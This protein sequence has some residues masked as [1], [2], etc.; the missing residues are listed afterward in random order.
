M[1]QQFEAPDLSNLLPPTGENDNSMNTP[2]VSGVGFN[3]Q[4]KS[5]V[6]SAKKIGAITKMVIKYSRGK[7]EDENQANVVVIGFIVL[8]VSILLFSLSGSSSGVKNVKFSPTVQEDMQNAAK[9]LYK[10]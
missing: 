3:V 4:N 9:T 10:Q 5:S 6:R 1:A 8:T 2:S 7:I